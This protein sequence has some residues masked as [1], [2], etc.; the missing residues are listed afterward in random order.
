MNPTAYPPKKKKFE[1]GVND[2]ATTFP[3]IAKE[4]I[5]AD[6]S[7]IMDTSVKPQEWKCSLCGNEWKAQP[8]SRV[9]VYQPRPG[10]PECK[11]KSAIQQRGEKSYFKDLYP[12]LAENAVDPEPLEGVTQSAHKKILWR[13]ELGHKYEMS[14]NKIL[15]GIKCP[16]CNFKEIDPEYN[17]IGAV[18]PDLVKELTNK[19]DADEILANSKKEISWSHISDDG[20]VHTWLASP[21]GRCYND[22]GC[23][24]CAGRQV[25][26]G[27]NNFGLFL[28]KTGYKWHEDNEFGPDDITLG[29]NK[30][31]KLYCDKHNIPYIMDIYAKFFTR[32]EMV[33]QDCIPTGD[34]F[35]SKPE[36]EIYEAVE[37][38][39]PDEH[40][41]NNVKR[42]K[43]HSVYDIDIFVNN[44]IAIDFHGSYWHQ[45]GLYKPVGYHKRKRD[46]MKRLGFAYLEVQEQDWIENRDMI[47][48]MVL[49]F[50]REE[51][52]S[53]STV[54]MMLT[55]EDK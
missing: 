27:V 36:R 16:V 38:E 34:K 15:N 14:P 7:E 5:S 26:I 8:R 10:C 48:D 35:R 20:V 43:R 13:C 2:L 4:L 23:L 46:S 50:V 25:Q 44:R 41:E 17:T 54:S 11:T 24:V 40:I 6:P 51:L 39:F 33:C 32:G 30:R 3:E 12:E 55:P 47:I 22:Y 18:R 49:Q 9:M 19:D 53:P 37:K 42:F 28:E 1:K 29:S 21:H 52:K 45:E 31:I